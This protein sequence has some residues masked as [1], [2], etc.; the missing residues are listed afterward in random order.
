M[1]LR[2]EIN[3]DSRDKS[4]YTTNE[5]G[6]YKIFIRQHKYIEGFS[7]F[8]GTPY[9]KTELIN[10]KKGDTYKYL[11]IYINLELDWGVQQVISKKKLLR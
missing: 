6:E 7:D 8:Y 2:L 11:G 9:S 4:T 1:L 5:D 10:T 3:Y